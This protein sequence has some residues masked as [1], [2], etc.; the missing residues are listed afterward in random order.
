MAS[1]NSRCGPY[2][3]IE[4][5][6]SWLTALGGK[7]WISLAFPDRPPSRGLFQWLLPDRSGMADRRRSTVAGSAVMW[8]P[9]MGPSVTFPFT[10]ETRSCPGN[11]SI[12]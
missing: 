9:S 4:W 11:Q 10:P 12:S 6:V 3:R 7:P 8:M 5:Q 1:G 2:A